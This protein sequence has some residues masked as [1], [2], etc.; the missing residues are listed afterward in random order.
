M[1]T[2]SYHNKWNCVNT[3]HVWIRHSKLI[4]ISQ[5]INTKQIH[6]PANIFIFLQNR[7]NWISENN[8][9]Q[10]VTTWQERLFHRIALYV[11]RINNNYVESYKLKSNKRYVFSWFCEAFSDCT[12]TYIRTCKLQTRND[13]TYPGTQSHT[14][15]H[16]T[17]PK[18]YSTTYYGIPYVCGYYNPYMRSVS[19]W[20]YGA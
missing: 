15:A 10:T 19:S 6:I 17:C 5:L 13:S 9:V 16:R 1:F 20:R 18:L 8:M 7:R 3:L 4:W 12:R 14:G 11:Y 2:K